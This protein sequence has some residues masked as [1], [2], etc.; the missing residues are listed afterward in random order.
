M[1]AVV[2]LFSL[3][4]RAYAL[5]ECINRL[6]GSSSSFLLLG[7]QHVNMLSLRLSLMDREFTPEDYELLRSLDELEEGN[8]QPQHL[9]QLTDHHLAQLPVVIFSKAAATK[10]RASLVSPVHSS[11]HG[12]LDCSSSSTW[13]KTSCGSSGD[14]GC[15]AS[16]AHPAPSSVEPAAAA[17]EAAASSPDSHAIAAG[18]DV[19]DQPVCAVCLETFEEG[20]EVSRAFA[21]QEAVLVSQVSPPACRI[22]KDR[23][24]R[25]CRLSGCGA[26]TSSTRARV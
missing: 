12:T 4:A 15:A 9:A 20:A 16:A 2:S 19:D 26:T 22:P 3:A 1:L 23:V 8:R 11:S 18:D 13:R 14:G 25:A 24:P 21:F 5:H 10:E 6:A 17:T 7:G